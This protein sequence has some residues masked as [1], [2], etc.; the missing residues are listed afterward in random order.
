MQYYSLTCYFISSEIYDSLDAEK[1]KLAKSRHYL[2]KFI[3]AVPF[4]S[5]QLARSIFFGQLGS[6]KK[7][8]K[9]RFL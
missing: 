4:L 7:L 8:S 5:Q 6:N 2:T 1:L 3:M 9:L